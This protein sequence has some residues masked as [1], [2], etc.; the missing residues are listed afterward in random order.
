MN[1]YKF[2]IKNQD[3]ALF[4]TSGEGSYPPSQLVNSLAT[5]S[6]SG[7]NVQIQNA[8]VGVDVS[9]GDYIHSLSNAEC[10]RVKEACYDGSVNMDRAFNSDVT[11]D[12]LRVVKNPKFTSISI[13]VTGQLNGII[14]GQS[15]PIGGGVTSSNTEGLSPV[16]YNATGTSMIIATLS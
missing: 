2:G 8:K 16:A 1:S 4:S 15:I 6:S 13:K 14:Q 12:E 3:T 9:P 5:F 11:S 10:I 7:I